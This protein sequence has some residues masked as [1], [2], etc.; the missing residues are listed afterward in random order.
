MRIPCFPMVLFTAFLFSTASADLPE[1]LAWREDLQVLAREMPQIHPDLFYRMSRASWDSAVAS[2]DQRLP[3]MRRNQAMVEMM[4]LVALPRDGHT[5]INPMFDRAL[6][7]RYYPI[8]LRSFE[9]GVYVVAAEKAYARYVGTRVTGIG[10][11]KVEQAL[12]AVA[13]TLPS[14]NEWWISAWAP[15]RLIIP[16]VLDGLGLV[17]DMERLPLRVE[18][19]AK[20]EVVTVKPA[21]RIEPR[22]HDPRGAIDRTGWVEMRKGP[23][24]AWQRQPG[25]PYWVEYR[26]RDSTLYVCYRAVISMDHGEAS[27]PFWRRVFAMADSLPVQRFVLDL[28]ENGGGNNFYNRQVVRGLIRRPA[29]DRSGRLFVVL[30]G[31]T[32][33]AAMNLALDLEKWTD[34][35]FVG[36]PTGNATFFF[37]DHRSVVLPRSGISVNVSTLPWRP[38]DPRDRRDYLAPRLYTPLTSAQYT[39]GQDPAMEA[40]L[41]YGSE[42]P[43]T[44][45]MEAAVLRGDSAGAERAFERARQER[46]NRFRTLEADV[47][48]LG[49]SL[50]NA[51]R[52]S[53]ALSVFRMN[54]RAY[55]RSANAWDSLGEALAISGM[56]EPAIAAYRKALA[57]DPEFRASRE[58]LA[59]L[60]AAH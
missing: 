59:R 8:Q 51:Q 7:V 28:R 30:G 20:S 12:A 49:Y 16:E 48:R 22:G 50:L 6:G 9:D 5:S 36:E 58:G 11:A 52:Q 38:Y 53:E 1:G 35:T 2:L 14:E 46:A 10:K 44:A 39:K 31:K 4:K 32:F 15:D 56:K 42:P 43:L 3:A 26:E 45:V 33:S 37:G 47:N 55:P 13:T 27:V 60:G 54:T 24:P 19:N 25:L 18:R 40:I 17:E 34:A 21:G 57:V 29:L 23:A 41:A